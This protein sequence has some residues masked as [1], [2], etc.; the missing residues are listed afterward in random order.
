MEFISY[1]DKEYLFSLDLFERLDDVQLTKL[2]ESLNDHQFP[3][4]LRKQDQILNLFSEELNF[5]EKGPINHFFGMLSYFLNSSAD[6]GEFESTIKTLFNVSKEEEEIKNKAIDFIYSLKL[7]KEFFGHRRLESYKARA[8]VYYR[9]LTYACD[10]RA[11]FKQDY[12][13]DVTPVEDYK[14]ELID[15]VPLATLKFF[16]ESRDNPVKFSFQADEEDLNEIISNL[17][18]AQ[19]ELDEIKQFIKE[20]KKEAKNE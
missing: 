7:L 18:A 8:N 5:K 17:L 15:L 6:Y 2:S 16:L 9:H 19:K 4:E 12:D 11:R 3:I 1:G 13:Y 20:A 10:L 14:P